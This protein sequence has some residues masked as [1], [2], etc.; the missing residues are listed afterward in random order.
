MHYD[1]QDDVAACR[2]CGCTEDAACAG[3]C[4]WVPDP[5]MAGDLCS[6]CAARARRPAGDTTSGRM[7]HCGLCGAEVPSWELQDHLIGHS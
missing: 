5:T 7:W 4:W 1:G 6:T 3:G 2:V